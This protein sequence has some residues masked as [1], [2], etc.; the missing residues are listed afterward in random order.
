MKLPVI[1]NSQMRTFR[2]CAREHQ[3]SYTLG[4]RPITTSE[5]LRIG[6][7][8]HLGLEAWWKWWM[9]L[10][11]RDLPHVNFSSALEAAIE[12]MMP[13]VIDEY[14]AVRAVVML[15][16]YDARWRDEPYD[17]IAV[18]SEFRAPLV[19][20][21]S[22]VASRTYVL[23]GKLDVLVRD[24]RDGLTKLVEHKTTSDDTS[25]GSDYWKRLLIDP[26]ISTYF[27]GSK[28]NG[29]DIAECVYDVLG[30]PALR[31]SASV[32]V[33]DEDGV[34]IVLDANGER[35]RTKDGKKWRESADSAQGYTMKVRMETPVEFHVR[36]ANHVA[37]N[38]NRYYVRG[39]V[40][41]LEA[42]EADAAH[43]AWHTARLIREAEIANRWPRNPDSCVR[44]SRTC[45]FF[46]VC[47]GTA[48]LDD[49]SRFRKV[50]N[51]HEE[52][53]IEVS[54]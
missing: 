15:T 40:V 26:Q 48:T 47:T 49:T 54:E 12:A 29:H 33:K 4:Y 53:S 31:P 11:T 10:R 35:V 46:G 5:A 22:G 9:C 50:E 6:I 28:A 1:T 34:K 24:R 37:E 23:G 13:H 14:D 21:E 38:P 17:V 32:P 41:R 18:E 20:P 3:L 42:E 39:K 43:D 19:N 36:L 16:G 7:L 25:D 8:A 2:R 30:K 27:A 52:L 51:P 45:D 44:Y